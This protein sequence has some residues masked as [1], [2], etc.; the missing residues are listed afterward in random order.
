MTRKGKKVNRYLSIIINNIK[1]LKNQM[2]KPHLTHQIQSHR[3]VQVYLQYLSR[4][5]YPSLKHQILSHRTHLNGEV[6]PQAIGITEVQFQVVGECRG[7]IPQ[8][9][10]V[11]VIA[12]RR[13][14]AVQLTMFRQDVLL[15]WSI[16]YQVQVGMLICIVQMEIYN[17]IMVIVIW[18]IILKLPEGH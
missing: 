15:I 6:D 4:L 16:G 14:Q 17:L 3:T 1:I 10:I 7:T 2:M 8:M 11:I 18:K 5:I 13:M 9:P 12:T